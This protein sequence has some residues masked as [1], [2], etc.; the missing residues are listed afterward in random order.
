MPEQVLRLGDNDQIALSEI[1]RA[2]HQLWQMGKDYPIWLLKGEMGAGKT[3]LIRTL[4]DV[5][6]WKGNVTSPT[7]SL[8]NEYVDTQGEPVYHFDFYRLKNE[9]E[10]YDMG[11]EEYLDSGHRCLIEWFERI[12]SLLPKRFFLVRLEMAWPSGRRIFYTTV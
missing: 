11:T 6:G 10:A 8:V 12:P 1:P 2:V 9:T 5:A 3:T 4:A 7:F